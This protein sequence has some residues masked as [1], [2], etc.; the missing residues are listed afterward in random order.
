MFSVNLLPVGSKNVLLGERGVLWLGY[1]HE[2]PTA[3]N[4]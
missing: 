4:K 3:E 1:P 2:P